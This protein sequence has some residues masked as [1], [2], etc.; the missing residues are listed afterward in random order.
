MNANWTRISGPHVGVRA[1]VE[2]RHRAPGDRQRQRERRAVDARRAPDVQLPGDERRAGRAVADERLR[3]P[4]RRPRARPA[5]SRPPASPRTARTGSGSF[6]IETGASTIST[7]PPGWPSC[8]AGPNSSTPTPCA[9]ASRAPAATSAG[10]RS[11]PLAS[12][13]MT[14]MRLS[15][16]DRGRARAERRPRDRRRCRTPGTR[17]AV[18]AGCG[19]AGTR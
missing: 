18:A 6:A 10:P 17:D 2:Q 16:R 15:G 7:P 9:A 14:V 3:A 11:A 1:D 8:A 19:S 4:R 5:R 12:T 13:A